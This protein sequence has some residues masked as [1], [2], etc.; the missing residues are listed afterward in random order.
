MK[1]IFFII[2]LAAV[3]TC[4]TVYNS[5]NEYSISDLTMANIEALAEGESSFWGCD[6]S[7]IDTYTEKRWD[8]AN[9]CNTS[10]VVI[11]YACSSGLFGGCRQGYVQS[12]Y[13]CEG[14]LT[15]QFDRTESGC[16][17]F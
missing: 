6:E 13:D 14:K 3:I 8:Y 17:L 4:F 10:T 12:Y 7:V 2:F 1:K 5:F 16:G 9:K 11:T 15:G